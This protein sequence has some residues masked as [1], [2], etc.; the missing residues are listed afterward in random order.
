MMSD[1]IDLVMTQLN[2]TAGVL[3][4][5]GIT[6]YVKSSAGSSARPETRVREYSKY[7][8]ELYQVVNT[9]LEKSESA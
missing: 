2:L 4:D 6:E 5:L 9:P 7:F 3:K 1:H 8:R